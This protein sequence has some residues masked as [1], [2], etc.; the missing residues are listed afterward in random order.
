VIRQDLNY[1]ADEVGQ[2]L[3]ELDLLLDGLD[4]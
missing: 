2:L 1:V 3:V 4:L